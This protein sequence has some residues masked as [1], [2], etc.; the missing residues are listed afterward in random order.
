MTIIHAFE[1]FVFTGQKSTKDLGL[2]NDADFPLALRPAGSWNPSLSE[3]IDAI[4]SFAS[5]GELVKLVQK[6]GGAALFRGLPIRT[7]QDYSEVAHA[8]GFRAH[9]EVGRPPL[10]T[11]LAKNVKT[12]N[13]G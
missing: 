10:R 8:F 1:S 12:A 7:A 2:P 3:S 6:H 5:S 13:E 9:E 11:V 4:K